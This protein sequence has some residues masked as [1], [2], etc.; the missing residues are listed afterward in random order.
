MINNNTMISNINTNNL[1]PKIHQLNIISNNLFAKL[2]N[3]LLT[4]LNLYAYSLSN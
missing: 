4:L 2:S 3:S 1:I